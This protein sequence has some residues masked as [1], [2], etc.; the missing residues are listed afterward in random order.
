MSK[1][2][3]SFTAWILVAVLM[4]AH[5]GLTAFATHGFGSGRATFVVGDETFEI[6]GYFDDNLPGMDVRLRDIAYILNGTPFQFDIR[7]YD[8]EI[9]DIF[10]GEPYTAIG[11]ELQPIDGR[12]YALFGSYGR[13]QWYGFPPPA[14]ATAELR[15]DLW[16]VPPEVT[17]VHLRV[18]GSINFGEGWVQA[19][20]IDESD[21]EIELFPIEFPLTGVTGTTLSI[22]SVDEAGE[23][24]F[25]YFRQIN[26]PDIA[27][28]RQITL[29]T[30]D[31]SDEVAYHTV[32]ALNDLDAPYFNILMLEEL[33]GFAFEDTWEAGVGSV[34]T[35]ITAH[36]DDYTYDA[37]E[38]EESEEYAP[39][40]ADLPEAHTP[41]YD[42]NQAAGC[43]ANPLHLRLAVAALV[44]I[45]LT[46]LI[47]RITRTRKNL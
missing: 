32:Y 38:Y 14:P 5:L 16:D 13:A 46:L 19:T 29:R 37:I 7:E 36:D 2:I 41:P 43:T 44:L 12:R 15:I 23:E 3:K 4:L 11:A 27:L 45:L 30:H 40:P 31:I 22:Y 39:A 42:S 10:T 28:R 20:V 18:R 34:Y 8:D 21:I 17:H 33:F 24:T 6:W 25:Q 47:V 26:F 1:L 35:L 9:W